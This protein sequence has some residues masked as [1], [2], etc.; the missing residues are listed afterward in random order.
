MWAL[1]PHNGPSATSR[2]GKPRLVALLPSTSA[3]RWSLGLVSAPGDS[4]QRLPLG[5]QATGLGHLGTGTQWVWPQQEPVQGC[6]RS[7]AYV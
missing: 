6:P 1:P 2:D 7:T 3:V 5:G 4:K